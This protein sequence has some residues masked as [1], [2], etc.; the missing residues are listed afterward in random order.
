MIYTFWRGLLIS[1]FKATEK[2]L[3]QLGYKIIK[4]GLE[5]GRSLDTQIVVYKHFLDT[6]KDRKVK[7]LPIYRGD[8][9][10]GLYCLMALIKLKVID[11][12]CPENGLYNPPIR[13]RRT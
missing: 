4:K 9:N 11:K 1:K 12:D 10:F 6:I 8:H 3:D 13:R 5:E 7:K 2:D